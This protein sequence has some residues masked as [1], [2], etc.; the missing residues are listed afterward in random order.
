MVFGA[1]GAA[2]S[3]AEVPLITRTSKAWQTDLA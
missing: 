3:K 2:K 1:N